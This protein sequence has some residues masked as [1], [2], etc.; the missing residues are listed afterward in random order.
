M[1]VSRKRHLAALQEEVWAISP[2]SLD[3]E[4]WDDRAEAES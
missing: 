4:M 2:F 3:E 1:Y